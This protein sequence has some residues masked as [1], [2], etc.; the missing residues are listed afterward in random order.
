MVDYDYK[1][2]IPDTPENRRKLEEKGI[3]QVETSTDACDWYVSPSDI[4]ED[5]EGA[6]EELEALIEEKIDERLMFQ[7]LIDQTFP[8]GYLV[9]YGNKKNIL[10]ETRRVWKTNDF[11]E[12]LEKL[13]EWIDQNF[14]RFLEFGND[15]LNGWTLVAWK[16]PTKKLHELAKKCS[17]IV[18]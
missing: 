8:N 13:R 7:R 15:D 1:F 17:E 2:F 11:W 3:T 4:A 16:V 6:E 14:S 10:D 12:A 5:W 9:I 18:C